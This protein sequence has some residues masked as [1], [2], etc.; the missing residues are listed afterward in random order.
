MGKRE[1]IAAVVGGALAIGFLQFDLSQPLGVAGGVP[2]VVLAAVGLLAQSRRL[3]IA[4]GILGLVLVAIGFLLSPPG[5][6]AAALLNRVLT[7][8]TIVV[9]ASLGYLLLRNQEEFEARLVSAANTDVLTGVRNRRAIMSDLE[10]RIAE[11]RRYERP[12]SLLLIDID[13][14]KRVNDTSGHLRG[15]DILREISAL[16]MACV[17]ETDSVGRYGGDEFL[18][19][20]PHTSAP[21]AFRVA[22][23]IRTTIAETAVADSRDGSARLT[24][25]IGIAPLSPGVET[26]TQLVSHA[27]HALYRAKAAGRNTTVLFNEQDYGRSLK[28]DGD[29]HKKE[30]RLRLVEAGRG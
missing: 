12:V 10:R 5:N 18:V 4:F 27:D 3:V 26:P 6:A 1:N 21:N 9:V 8:L 15:D 22:E 14:F 29:R 25:S 20:C 11:A 30:Q 28:A 16:C 23:R 13:H 19:V 2:Y 7:A 24:V 17:R